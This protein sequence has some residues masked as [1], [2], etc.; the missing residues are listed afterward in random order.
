MP[1]LKF[2]RV[3]ERTDV[4]ATGEQA[5][6]ELAE[7]VRGLDVSATRFEEQRARSLAR[8]G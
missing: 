1:V 7:F 6:T 4:G 8:R 2:W 3:F 5:R